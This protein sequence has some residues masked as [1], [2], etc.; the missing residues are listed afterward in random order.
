MS[1]RQEDA[2]DAPSRVQAYRSQ[3]QNVSI[4]GNGKGNG[5]PDGPNP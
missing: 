3:L 2:V 4:D 1:R 5:A